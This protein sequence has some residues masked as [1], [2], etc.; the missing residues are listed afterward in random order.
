MPFRE[1]S[2][3]ESYFLMITIDLYLIPDGAIIFHNASE[4]FLNYTVQVNDIRIHEYHRNNGITKITY[5]NALNPNMKHSML[6]VAEGQLSLIDLV[7]R[8]Y[9]HYLNPDVWLVSGV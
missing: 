8:S 2:D 1:G 3:I 9:L 4:R 7:S 5:K 6:M